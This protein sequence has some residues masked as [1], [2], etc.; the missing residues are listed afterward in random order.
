MFPVCSFCGERPVVVWF[1]GPDFTTSV[2]APE[3]VSAEEAWLS[4]SACLELVRADDREALV[5]RGMQRLSGRG[6]GSEN[7]EPVVRRLQ[8]RFWSARPRG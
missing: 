6:S 1:E 2:D 4:C 8:D 5:H 3:D 7:V